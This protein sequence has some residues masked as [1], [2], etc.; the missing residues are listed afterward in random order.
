LRESGSSS[1]EMARPMCE[2]GAKHLMRAN[3][4]TVHLMIII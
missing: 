4:N 1:T 3:P 2:V